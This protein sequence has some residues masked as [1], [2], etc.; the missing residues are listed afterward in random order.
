ME[1]VNSVLANPTNILAW[2]IF[3]FIAGFLVNLLDPTDNRGL[4]STVILGILGAIVGGFISSLLL[5]TAVVGFS[6]EGLIAA[7]IGGLILAYV[8]R[9]IYRSGQGPSHPTTRFTG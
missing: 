2:I 4:I 3:G 8:A 1:A 9:N 6:F 5:G 7:V